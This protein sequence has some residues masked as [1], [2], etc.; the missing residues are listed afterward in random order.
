MMRILRNENAAQ[1][2]EEEGQ[3]SE[4]V[5]RAYG[6][7]GGAQAEGEQGDDAAGQQAEGNGVDDREEVH[8]SPEPAEPSWGQGSQGVSTSAAGSTGLRT[9]ALVFHRP[10]R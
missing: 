9:T 2:H 7:A 6:R 5:Q 3:E 8:D 10:V 4:G 1:R